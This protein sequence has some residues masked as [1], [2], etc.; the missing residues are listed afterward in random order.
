MTGEVLFLG[1]R[2]GVGKTSVGFEVHA[3]LAAAGVRH[4]HLEGDF[5]DMAHP[6]PDG[7]FEANLAAVWRNYTANG[8]SRMIYVNTVS[9]QATG[10][11]LDVLH[12][13][14]AAIGVLLTCTDATAR[15]RLGGREIG[16]TLQH[17]IARSDQAAVELAGAPGWVHRVATDGRSVPEIAAEVVGLSG[18]V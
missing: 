18:W 2:S 17:H 16:S 13:R 14:P 10:A 8:Y 11:L 6:S 4:F 9:V 7:V 1:G 12:P 5:L 3:Q 15:A